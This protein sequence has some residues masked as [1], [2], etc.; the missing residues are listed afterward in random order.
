[1]AALPQSNTARWW[2]VYNVNSTQ[3]KLMVRTLGSATGAQMNTVFNT[4]LG[5]V[6]AATNQ[7]TPLNLEF[8]VQGSNVRNTV[9]WTG[10]PTYGLGTEVGTDGRARTF[11]A[12]G[13]ST[14]GRKSK[15][16]IFGA[17]TFSEGD[18]RVD[19]GEGTAVANL[20]THLNS[21]SGVYLSISGLQPVWKGYVNI[22]FNDHWIKQYRKAGG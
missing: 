18:Y 1:M 21:A 13:R 8:A 3:H 20:I 11:S 17:K 15:L 10:A 7:I 16:F 2:L 9:A 4:L 22:G 19:I 14:D 5:I 6:S 12:V